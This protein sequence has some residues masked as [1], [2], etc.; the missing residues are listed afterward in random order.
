ML[1]KK[2]DKLA[3]GLLASLLTT[4]VGYA[5]VLLF[6]ETIN[7]LLMGEEAGEKAYFKEAFRERTSF[8]LALSLNIIT[9]NLFKKNL[10]HQAVKGIILGTFLGIFLWIVLYWKYFFGA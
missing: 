2:Y 9:L 6:F 8:I 4:L 1:D 10:Q 5:L 7:D 3:F